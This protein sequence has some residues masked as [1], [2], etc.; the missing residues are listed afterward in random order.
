M[1]ALHR[2]ERASTWWARAAGLFVAVECLALQKLHASGH[3][4]RGALA[5][6]LALDAALFL[7]LSHVLVA[8]PRGGFR[9]LGLSP[10]HALAAGLVALAAHRLIAGMVAVPTLPLSGPL[11]FAGLELLLFLFAGLLA[12]HLARREE[13]ERPAFSRA[14]AGALGMLVP[15]PLAGVFLAEL[16]ILGAATRALRREPLA[17]HAGFAV[18]ETS[19]YPRL[20]LSLV[21]LSVIEAPATH[22]MV[23]AFVRTHA[24]AAHLVLLFVHAYTFLWIA[25]DLRMLREARHVCE[26]LGLRITLGARATAFVPYA[27]ILEL[28]ASPLGHTRALRL[29]PMDTPN[30]VLVLRRPV[31]VVRM[32][33]ITQRS[34]CLALY[35]DDPEALRA[36]LAR[37]A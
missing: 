17:P 20:A 13:P 15:R 3:L 27:D 36:E 33:G 9:A 6:V 28:R 35:L 16:A 11:V 4:P 8:R 34:D 29:T 1:D 19:N 30:L 25:G 31:E 32:L 14:F 18:L 37:R 22:L 5:L 10:R 12:W 21:L 24:L 26:E 2:H 7:G 23:H